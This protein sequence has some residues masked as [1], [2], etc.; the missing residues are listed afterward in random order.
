MLK[1]LVF[2]RSLNVKYRGGDAARLA[3]ILE[4]LFQ[5][6]TPMPALVPP[7]YGVCVGVMTSD[8]ISALKNRERLFFSMPMS[9][10][11]NLET[12]K[13]EFQARG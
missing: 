2:L 13:P 12:R 4:H 3:L 9:V 6:S 8:A 5:P 1:I 11:P 10:A 7:I